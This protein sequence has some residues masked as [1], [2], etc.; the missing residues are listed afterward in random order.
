MALFL[1]SLMLAGGLR[2]QLLALGATRDALFH[3][4]A[5]RSLQD[6]VRRES[7]VALLPLAPASG[8]AAVPLGADGAAPPAGVPGDWLA[9]SGPQWRGPPAAT[10]CVERAG[11]VLEL[12][13]AWPAFGRPDAIGAAGC[14]DTDAEVAL[15]VPLP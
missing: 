4:R 2:T 12:A 9:A 14:A 13:L 7:V 3:A 10:L 1:F 5:L 6:L 8:V 15:L 11:P